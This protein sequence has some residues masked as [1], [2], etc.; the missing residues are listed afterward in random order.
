M[1]SSCITLERERAGLGLTFNGQIV[2]QWCNYSV[3]AFLLHAEANVKLLCASSAVKFFSSVSDSSIIIN[4]TTAAAQ[5][6]GR[7]TVACVA[8]FG[9]R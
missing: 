9:A 6:D 4:G 2:V 8:S 5:F 7:S 1:V 3:A